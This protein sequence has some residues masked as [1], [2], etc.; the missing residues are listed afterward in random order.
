MY[1][2]LALIS[3]LVAGGYWGWYF[4]RHEQTRLYGAL[5]VL[6]AALC[7]LGLLGHRLDK[8]ELGVPGAIGVGAG[9]CLLVLG[10]IA[11]GIARR[12][13]AAERFTLAE[14]LLDVADVLAPGS[15]VGDEKA[16]L[17][18]MREI[19]D[20]NIEQTVDALTAAK[21]RA[22]A[23]ARLAIDERIA[24]LYLASY[25]WDEAI[26]HAEEHLFGALPPLSEDAGSQVALRR[27][28]GI[29]PPVWVELLGAYGYKGELDQAAVM[30]ARLEEVC[31]GRP[32]AGIWLH[33]GRLIFL[34]L[35]GRI[36]A[37]QALVEPKR[38]RH[39]KAAARQYWVAVAHERHGE[40][41][42]AQAAYA[43]ARARSRGRPRVLIDQA[44][45]RLEQAKPAELGP[46]ASEVVARVEAEPVPVVVQRMRP[47]GP[48]ATR[49]L[50][51]S[52]L[53]AATAI[54]FILDGS[55]DVGTLM[56]SGAMVRGL[57]H[58]G[59]WWRLVTFSFVHVGGIHLIVNM[60]GLWFLGRLTEDLFGPWRTIAI[61]ALAGIGGAAASYLASPAGISAGASGA[62]FG[63]LG[64][65]FI[66]LSWH[67]KRH[68][69]AWSRGVWGSLA[70]VTVAQVGIGFIYP[71]ID[72]WAHGAGLAVGTLAGI[73][74][75]PS[76]RWAK[77]GD[78]VAR[79]VS[80]AFGVLVVVCAVLVV[81]T[82]IADS[83]AAAPRGLHSIGTV[84]VTAPASWHTAKGELFDADLFIVLAAE[85]V[86]ATGPL[87]AQ[88]A[89]YAKDEPARAKERH[90]DQVEA[91]KDQ[92]IALPPGWQ[93]SELIVSVA[94]PLG[95]RQRYR[96]V[97]AARPDAGGAVLASLYVPDTVAR[98]APDYFTQLLA[99]VQ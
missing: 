78:H 68:R 44:L 93:G 95:G 83:L 27:V 3:V 8:S 9:V 38:S 59:E 5:Q 52:C 74:L 37:V 21:D 36:E 33:R 24:M 16:L 32:D 1:Y 45:A 67:R 30:L 15:G 69:A 6:A 88:L 13:A 54:G 17:F 19:R 25:R 48:I 73:V 76:T 26:I 60:I 62:L 57:V 65:V 34:A 11:R 10:P 61:F 35:A 84:Q 82:S 94:D 89:A 80:I 75:S 63:M 50:V 99:S 43:K 4:V 58:D 70:V 18:A 97:I 49:L 81:R 42:A 91:A 53:L 77:A 92:V 46:T 98:A 71:V 47:R 2:E 31:A 96:V 85:R 40:V 20:G 72:Q 64:A 56:R 28:L 66:E 7:G 51:L 79:A 39:M 29:A 90:F 12:F 41:A 22:P 86:R 87:A 14:K 55:T 23:D